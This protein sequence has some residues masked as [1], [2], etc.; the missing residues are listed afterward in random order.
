MLEAALSLGFV[1]LV[2]FWVV[3]DL[4]FQ[5]RIRRL[6]YEE[7]AI[8]APEGGEGGPVSRVIIGAPEMTWDRKMAILRRHQ[9]ISLVLAVLV[10]ADMSG[11]FAVFRRDY[12][13]QLAAWQ[14]PGPIRISVNRRSGGHPHRLWTASFGGYTDAVPVS[15]GMVLVRDMARDATGLYLIDRKGNILWRYE[16]RDGTPPGLLWT[17][18]TGSDAQGRLIVAAADDQDETRF[19]VFTIDP[20]VG[21]VDESVSDVAPPAASEQLLPAARPVQRLTIEG[22]G[23]RVVIT[24]SSGSLLGSPSSSVSVYDLGP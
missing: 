11:S 3:Y 5:R 7:T 13:S 23:H 9:R 16:P 14:K 6:F 15:G 18:R 1:G 21:R 19:H 22:L 8:P 20:V 12:L 10:L 24:N 2:S 4:I 17:I